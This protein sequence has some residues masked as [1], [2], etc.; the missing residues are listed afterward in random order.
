MHT[1]EGLTSDLRV[2]TLQSLSS[3]V[4]VWIAGFPNILNNSGFCWLVGFVVVD[5]GGFRDRV[6][7]RS[8]GYPGPCSVDQVGLEPN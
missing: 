6:Y 8:P 3:K 1:T 7:L 2:P 5:G 4:R